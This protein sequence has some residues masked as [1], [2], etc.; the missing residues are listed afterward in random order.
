MMRCSKTHTRFTS[1][2]CTTLS[3]LL[4]VVNAQVTTA[5]SPLRILRYSPTDTASS[6][7]IISVTF[8][9]PVAGQLD[10]TID[11]RR[12]ISVEPAVKGVYEWRDPITLR[13]VPDEPLV[14]GARHVVSID[15]AAIASTGA[16][17]GRAFQF[18]VRVP[19]AVRIA[20]YADNRGV[21]YER[22]EIGPLPTFKIVYSAAVNIDSVEQLTRL[23]L[24]ANCGGPIPLR[25]LRQRALQKG[26]PWTRPWLSRADTLGERFMRVVEL[27]T[28][29]SLKPGC[30]GAWIVPLFNDT[31]GRV[32]EKHEIRT[33]RE[34]R[35][36]SMTGCFDQYQAILPPCS[37]DSAVI[38][39]SAPVDAE[40]IEKY[41]HI[42]PNLTFQ[43]S[44]G[45]SNTVTFTGNLAPR[46]KYTVT[47]DSAVRDMY[48]RKLLGSHTVTATARDRAPGVRYQSALVTLS[49]V[50]PVFSVRTV[51]V[52]T[53]TMYLTPIPDSLFV[54]FAGVRG[55]ARYAMIEQLAKVLPK[56]VAVDVPVTGQFN[57]ETTISV[58]LPDSIRERFRNSLFGVRFAVKAASI[59]PESVEGS[60]VRRLKSVRVAAAPRNQEF[61]FPMLA[62]MSRLRAHSKALDGQGSVLVTDDHGKVVT[63]ANVVLFNEKGQRIAVAVS[64]ASG[65]AVLHPTTVDSQFR[66]ANSPEFDR[67][68]DHVRL[69]EVTK[70]GERL[71][72]PIESAIGN[73]LRANL[74]PMSL[75]VDLENGEMLHATLFTDRGIYRPGERIYAK[76]YVRY[77]MVGSILP[78]APDSVRFTLINQERGEKDITRTTLLNGFGAAVDS[79]QLAATQSVARYTVSAEVRVFGIWRRIWDDTDVR[80]AEF[81]TPDFK[82]ALSPDT[83]P[84]FAGDTIELQVDARYLYGVSMSGARVYWSAAVDPKWE[85]TRKIPNT[86]GYTIGARSWWDDVTPRDYINLGAVDSLNRDGQVTLRIPTKRSAVPRPSRLNIDV[87]VVDVNN[88]TVTASTF[89][90][91]HTSTYNIAAKIR[92]A[93]WYWKTGVMQTV[94]AFVALENGERIAGVPL[95]V[96]VIRHQ[97]RLDTASTE[98]LYHWMQDTVQRL[99][100]VTTSDSVAIR[101]TPDRDGAYDVLIEAT[102]AQG[103]VA[104]TNIGRWAYS[105][106]WQPSGGNPLRLLVGT[107]RAADTQFALG[108]TA[109][110]TFQSPFAKATAWLTL[111]REGVVQQIVKSATLG[112]N[113][114]AV[115]I[116]EKYAPNIMAGVVLIARTD[117]AATSANET[118]ELLRVG[119]TEIR[120]DSTTHALHVAIQPEKS[121]LLPADTSRIRVQVRDHSNRG[122]HSEVTLWAVD[123]GALSLTDYQTPD[124]LAAIDQRLGVPANFYS[125]ITELPWRLASGRVRPSVP[126]GNLMARAGGVSHLSMVTIEQPGQ[127][128]PNDERG[129]TLRSKFRLTAFYVGSAVTDSDGVAVIQNQLPDNITTFRLMATAVS[130]GERYGT[131]ESSLLVTRRVVV[132]AALP[133]FVRNGD[134]VSI[135]AAVGVRDSSNT[136]L[137]VHAS[138][139]PHMLRDDSI[140]TV[141]VAGT[142]N[143]RALFSMNVPEK[144]NDDSVTIRFTAVDH[145][146]K[147]GDAV[148]TTLPILPAG[149]PRAH[150]AIG[151]VRDKGSIT[152]TLPGKIDPIR[153]TISVSLGTSPLVAMRTHFVRLRDYTYQSTEVITT[154]ARA[155]LSLARAERSMGE[156][157]ITGDSAKVHADLQHAVDEIA[158]RHVGDG[159]FSN[160]PGKKA[161]DL[162]FSAYIGSFLRDAADEGLNV[163]DDLQDEIINHMSSYFEKLVWLDDSLTVGQY[164]RKF[165]ARREVTD[166]LVAL[167]YLRDNDRPNVKAEDRL[168]QLSHLLSWEDNVGL[169]DLIADRRELSNVATTMLL[170]AWKSVSVAGKRIDMPDSLR[171]PLLFPSHV[172]PAAR[173]LLTTMKLMPEHPMIGALAETIIQQGSAEQRW[174]WNSLDYGSAIEA[175]SQFAV[176]QRESGNAR[177]VARAKNGW[178]LFDRNT[179]AASNAQLSTADSTQS[180][181]GMIE[182]KGSDSTSVT[183]A[184]SMESNAMDARISRKLPLYFS[185]TVNEIPLQRP[186]TPDMKGLTVERWYEDFTTGK[187]ITEVKEGQLVRVRLRV[188]VPADRQYVALE[189]M[190]PAGLEVVDLSLRTSAAIGPFGKMAAKL[191]PAT[192]RDDDNDELFGQSIQYGSWDNGWWSPWDYKEAR[193]DRVFYF[194]NELWSGTYSATYLARATTPGTFTKPPAHVEEMYNRALQ[195][196]SDGGVFI[197]RR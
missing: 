83:T 29:D 52:D 14:P 31:H 141:S 6:G 158:K 178:V 121:Q 62:Q 170:N 88:Q 25:V 125:T 10:R 92:T 8:S 196:R 155:L 186:V 15:T 78:L 111:E 38:W 67:Y 85:T 73:S 135:G 181:G 1:I 107:Q 128:L 118:N 96:K 12:V 106:S 64:N 193:D 131:G 144:T 39:L 22:T 176:D 174:V 34:F 76:A 160:W 66:V 60:P 40:V 27:A 142:Q 154:A 93:G 9:R 187:P 180:L 109:R 99:Q 44:S 81:R 114:W 152:L 164:D 24:P 74:E 4:L 112:T 75:G 192:A 63:A 100:I 108:D 90:D 80:V 113:T 58:T 189:D 18:T 188:T 86:T 129:I 3:A 59:A 72:V 195:G 161:E 148:A 156:T 172:R 163:S 2:L 36:D 95:S 19:S 42:T 190:L 143:E 53:L 30:A 89:V 177:L 169:A 20:S 136:N 110:I 94:D 7:S 70:L 16:R 182:R 165:W 197:V 150:T 145:R 33:A 130:K 124:I 119:F 103:R 117:S 127:S 65:L 120:V 168:L 61:D 35:I 137:T 47:I 146:L 157:I 191:H 102:D 115:P 133:R 55:M 132:R 194:A 68:R 79:F 179:M 69:L 41:V 171:S 45:R 175:L 56:T 123:E 50:K 167:R 139:T 185:V 54:P 28:L 97:Y 77:G 116:T 11:A 5:Q 84:R 104:Q 21:G 140:R 126:Y 166:R 101:F 82:V 151:M 71:I 162:W 43:N 173:L 49:S 138:V 98:R 32:S 153:S 57:T 91:L 51:N 147:D 87:G 122:V 183:L 48:G 105:T 17:K 46:T 159:L 149:T 13:F 26:D 37:E 23:E 134:V 184:L